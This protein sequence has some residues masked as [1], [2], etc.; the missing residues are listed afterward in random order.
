[1]ERKTDFL[2]LVQH[3][4]GSRRPPECRK[5]RSV[6]SMCFFVQTE[7][8][9]QNK[10]TPFRLPHIGAA[11]SISPIV[12]L[13]MIN[14]METTARS[15]KKSQSPPENEIFLD[16]SVPVKHLWHCYS[17]N[18]AARRG[19]VL[20]SIFYLLLNQLRITHHWPNAQNSHLQL[21]AKRQCP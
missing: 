14:C 21:S 9:K 4:S 19:S 8:L 3:C 10:L 16:F 15:L 6:T 2:V 20:S 12:A 5:L 13:V 1:M 11:M 18:T 17:D 7:A